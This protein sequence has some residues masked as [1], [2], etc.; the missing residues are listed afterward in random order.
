MW[1]TYILKSTTKKWYYV[2][3]TN[4]I[5]ERVTEHNRGKTASTKKYRPLEL[6]FIKEFNLEEEARSYEQKL[7]KCRKEKKL[8]IRQ[9]ENNI[10]Q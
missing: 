9:I 1:T 10:N 2:G 8:I 4:R 6:V 3:S 5:T 7:K